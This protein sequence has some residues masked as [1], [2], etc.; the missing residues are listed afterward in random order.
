[1]LIPTRYYALLLVILVRLFE[2]YEMRLTQADLVRIGPEKFEK[3]SDCMDRAHYFY[4]VW[5]QG[6]LSQLAE[7]WNTIQ[8]SGWKHSGSS[9]HEDN[10]KHETAEFPDP[11]EP[12]PIKLSDYSHTNHDGPIR[13]AN[14]TFVI[15]VRNSDLKDIVESLKQ[16]EDRFN[17]Q[18]HYPYVFLNE[19]PFSEEFKR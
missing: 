17:R 1:M 18:F 2:L 16:I 9:F 5:R 8:K 15:L 3:T 12:E 10:Y 11:R 14:A 7:K 4:D 19:K 6:S 13:K